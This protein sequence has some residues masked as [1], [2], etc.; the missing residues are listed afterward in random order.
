M[1]HTV[2]QV[3]SRVGLPEGTVRYYDRI[4]L[5]TPDARSS[6][7]YRL[8]GPEEEGKLRFVRQAKS[9]G[10]SLDDIRGLIAAAE[11]GCCGEVIPELDR[12]LNDKLAEID[13]QLA[14]LAAFR[15]RLVTFRTGEGAGCGCRRHGAFCGCLDGASSP[16]EP[17]VMK[18]RT[19]EMHQSKELDMV[20]TCGCASS[21]G[22]CGCGCDGSCGCGD[23]S[24]AT[25]A[26]EQIAELEQAKRDIDQRLV[27]LQRS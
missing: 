27:E 14:E 6:A 11:R 22:G 2:K 4:G 15:A 20:N 13:A 16:V 5:V 8:Y 26:E 7:G 25:S 1:E 24:Q 21:A 3:A 9:L 19:T 23:T 17:T 18:G 12:L 10:L